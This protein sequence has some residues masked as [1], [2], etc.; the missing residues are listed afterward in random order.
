[1][2]WMKQLFAAASSE[3]IKSA[4]SFRC[5]LTIYVLDHP[6]PG[7]SDTDAVGAASHKMKFVVHNAWITGLNYNDLQ[8]QGNEVLY[9]NISLVHEGISW[10]F[11]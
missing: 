2:D 1:M 11:V 10:S 3:G 8:A 7:A 6:V 5:N 9:E 4:N